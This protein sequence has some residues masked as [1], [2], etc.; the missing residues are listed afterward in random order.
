MKELDH[1]F[2]DIKLQIPNFIGSKV[3]SFQKK[4]KKT[5]SV[6]LGDPLFGVRGI[7]ESSFL[8]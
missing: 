8:V 3:I 2:I 4:Q 1:N 7:T 6:F 5:K